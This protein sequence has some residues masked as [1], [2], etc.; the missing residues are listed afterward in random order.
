MILRDLLLVTGL[1]DKFYINY[2]AKQEILNWFSKMFVIRFFRK[3]RIF[4]LDEREE[5]RSSLRIVFLMYK[6]L[7]IND[8]RCECSKF[9]ILA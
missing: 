8:A 1:S 3:T 2:S 4:K 5:K 9:S 7:K 6:R